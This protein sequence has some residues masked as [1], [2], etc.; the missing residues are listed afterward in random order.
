MNFRPTYNQ[1]LAP[2]PILRRL[3]LW[4]RSCRTQRCLW[5]HSSWPARRRQPWQRIPWSQALLG[6]R[7]GGTSHTNWL[8]HLNLRLPTNPSIPSFQNHQ[9]LGK[10]H[11]YTTHVPNTST[12]EAHY[13]HSSNQKV[14]EQKTDLRLPNQHHSSSFQ[15]HIIRLHT[16]KS[17]GSLII[18]SST[19]VTIICCLRS[20]KVL[21]VWLDHLSSGKQTWQ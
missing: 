1:S 9:C 4:Q 2:S 17:I 18:R 20:D 6:I 15:V 7:S 10:T 19:L 5:W 13:Q 8:V 14:T 11:G 12:T 21:R 3:D 16:D